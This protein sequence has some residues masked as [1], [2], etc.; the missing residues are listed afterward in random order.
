MSYY[1]DTRFLKKD[2]DWFS[3]HK[4]CF[5]HKIDERTL[6]PFGGVL[7]LKILLSSFKKLDIA[8]QQSTFFLINKAY[9]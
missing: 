3:C 1:R 7:Y 5:Y 6:S 8:E 4:I 2:C 9:K